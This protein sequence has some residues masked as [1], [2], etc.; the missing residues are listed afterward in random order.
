MANNTSSNFIWIENGTKF[1]EHV[2]RLIYLIV[3]VQIKKKK[4]WFLP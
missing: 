1:Y 2:A 4:I 3:V